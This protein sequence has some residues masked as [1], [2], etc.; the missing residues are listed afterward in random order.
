MKKISLLFLAAIT[1]TSVYSQKEYR[2]S[3]LSVEHISLNNKTQRWHVDSKDTLPDGEKEVLIITKYHISI[4]G[5][6]DT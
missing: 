3:L 4:E 5:E 6:F 1:V 2:Y